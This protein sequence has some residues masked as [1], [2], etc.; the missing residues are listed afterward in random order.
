MNIQ[1]CGYCG[2]KGNTREDYACQACE[3]DPWWQYQPYPEENKNSALAEFKI[4][5][6]FGFAEKRKTEDE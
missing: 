1:C 6:E 4:L 2:F 3:H 5:I